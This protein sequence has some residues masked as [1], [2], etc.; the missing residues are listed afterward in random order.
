V[1]GVIR[2]DF[3]QLKKPVSPDS[4]LTEAQVE[5]MV[6]YAISMAGG[7]HTIIEPGTDWVVIKVNIVELKPR[8]SGVITDCRVVKALVKIVHEIVPEARITIA[9][10]SGEWIPPDRADI[11]ATVPRAKLGDGFEVAGYRALLRDEDLAGISLDIVDLNFDE[12]VEV[13]VPDEWYAREKYY[14]PSTILECDVLISVPVLKVHDG[15]GMTNAMKNFVGIAPGMIYGWAKMLG[16]PPG[17]GN[18]GI[19]HTPEILDE[20]I[21]DLTSLSDVDFTVVDAIIAMERFK[22]EGWGGA[23]KAVRMNTI[24]ASAD[25]VAADAVSARLMGFNPDDIEYLTLAAYKGLGQCDLETI[26]VNGNPIEQV[27]RRFEKCPADWG[28]W[29]EQGHYGQGARTWLLKGPFE[30]GEMEA[31]SIDLKTL[32]PVPDQDGWSKPVYF[33]DDR[34]DLDTYYGDPVNC[35]VYA[36]AEFTAPKSQTAELWVGSGEDVRVWINSAE[37]Y[38]YQ[39]V[40]RHRLPNDREEIP[41]E[42]G[43]N[44]LLVQA[45]QTRGGFDFNVNLCEPESDK[46]YDGNRVFGL[47]FSIPE[48]QVETASVGIE[49]VVGFRI[50]E[51]LN[52]TDE[53]DRFDQGAWTVYTTENGLS[54][55]RVR[56]MAFGPDGSLWVV[57][58]GLCRFD[59]KT[60]ASYAQDESFPDGHIGEVAVDREGGVWFASNRGLYS[61]DGK[62]ATSQLSGWINFVMVDHQGRVWSAAWGE[63]ASVY[64]GDSWKTYTERDGLSDDEVTDI[65]SDAHGTLWM[66]TWGRGVNRF[67]G[68]MWTHYSTDDGLRD[69]H[70]N[71]ITADQAGNIWIAMDDNGL[72]RFDGKTWTNY[73]KQDGLAGRDARALMVT[74]EGSAWVATENNGLSRFDGQ[75][76]ITGICN[77]EVRSI[78]QGPDGRIWF[79]SGGGGVAVLGE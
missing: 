34:I 11:K 77:E 24:V 17:S 59:G 48:T 65:V 20:T 12:A 9:E 69:N 31:T 33:H 40:R 70:I 78:V 28:K 46:R 18:P 19:P 67:D 5:H 73:G 30:I 56:S 10:G 54:S 51:W 75:R 71:S 27:A 16:Y 1:V 26:K 32:N 23:G 44:T 36:Y 47:K 7:L 68:K 79:G 13:T 45:K 61:F 4:A 39:G 64:D 49:E 72:S 55:N 35:V 37:V 8:G 21:V 76:W 50:N 22:T 62:N 29:G 3:E 42:E 52:L 43:R 53:A 2:S 74:R 25:I 60:W 38:A 6:R 63:G 15:V 57:A 14:I 58:D 66:A 41:I